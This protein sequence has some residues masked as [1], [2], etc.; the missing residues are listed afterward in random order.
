MFAHAGCGGEK[1]AGPPLPRATPTPTAAA[2]SAPA[3][4]AVRPLPRRPVAA[5]VTADGDLSA[6]VTVRGTAGAEQT[7]FV[8]SDCVAFGC[9]AVVKSDASGGFSVNV[10]VVAALRRPRA[11]ITVEVPGQR[12]EQRL[13]VRLTPAPG[14]LESDPDDDAAAEPAAATPER[15]GPAPRRLIM[16]GDSLA[17]GT[18]DLLPG[19]LPGWRVETDAL[20]SRPLATGMRILSERGVFTTPVVLAF[21][22]FSNDT[23]SNAGALERAVRQS[24]RVAG[25][26]GCAIWATLERPPF[27]GQS[28]DAVNDRLRRLEQELAGRMYLVDWEAAVAANPS[29]LAGD[30]VHATPAGYRGRAELFAQAAQACGG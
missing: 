29:W 15:T 18:R 22:L 28:Y 26:Q 1:A 23:P 2:T 8:S 6:R 27:S 3:A 9:R 10:R 25:R 21:S 7:V 24:V 14:Q 13:R 17:V 20:T 19:L 30:K 16:I 11:R 4:L 5:K 12:L